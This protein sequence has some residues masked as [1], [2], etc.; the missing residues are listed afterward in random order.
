MKF[1][2]LIVLAISLIIPSASLAQTPPPGPSGYVE[3]IE[4]RGSVGGEFGEVDAGEAQAER[5][6]AGKP[7]P[8]VSPSR[9][10]QIEEIVVQARKRAE[11]LED[12][13][14]SV[15]ALGENT[16][17]EAGVTRLDDIQELVPNLQ[18]QSGTSGLAV[19]IVIR[20][21]GT[22]QSAAIAFD[23]GV[24]VYVDGVYL[25]RTIGALIDVINLEQVEVL[26]G[27]QGTLFGK[28]TVGG[29]IN[30]TTVKPKDDYEGFVLLRPGNF[31]SIFTQ[32]SKLYR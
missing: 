27:P 7:V 8:G 30:I 3:N 21:V 26:R 25:P 23:P 28:N 4:E 20:G 31:G 2:R 24:G 9:A 32:G 10:A 18:F 29:A 5:L 22:P 16:L 6:E 12:T 17:R 15:T 1:I 19:N 13:P 11:F 14:I